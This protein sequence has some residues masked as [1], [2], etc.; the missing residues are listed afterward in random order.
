MLDFT[1]GQM[2]ATLGHGHPAILDAMREAGGR[3]VHLFSGFLSSDVTELAR[4]L[5]AL[6]PEPLSRAMFLS[7][8]GEAN[9]AALR[10]AKTSEL[11]AQQLKALG[12]EVRTHIGKTGVVGVLKGGKPGPVV[13][14]RA[15]MDALPVKEMTGLPFASSATGVRRGKTVPVM[16][17]CGH[18]THTAMLLGAAKVLAQHRNEVAGTVVSVPAG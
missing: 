12:L 1:S 15:D 13:A 8:G 10:L 17:A 14:L 16:H 5:M 11:V 7:T 3:A 6:L 2:C 18:D 9:E 4:E